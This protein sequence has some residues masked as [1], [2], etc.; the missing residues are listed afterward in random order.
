LDVTVVSSDP[1][2]QLSERD[3]GSIGPD[4]SSKDIEAGLNKDPRLR[5]QL[6]D[7]MGNVYERLGL[8]S[9]AHDLLERPAE[10]RQQVLGPNHP[11]TL[12]SMDGLAWLLSR[13]GHL[14]EAEKLQRQILETRRKSVSSQ[15]PE[16][17]ERSL[18]RLLREHIG[19]VHVSGSKKGACDE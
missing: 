10:V 7:G 6:M 5:A 2:P 12:H 13:E 15:S 16:L 3:Y 18:A 11:D 19:R 17:A 9:R 14:P 1:N 4:R 8:Y